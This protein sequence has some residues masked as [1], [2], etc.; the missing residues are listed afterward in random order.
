MTDSPG[1]LADR[2]TTSADLL[3]SPQEFADPPALE[4]AALGLGKRRDQRLLPKL[5]EMLDEPGFTIRVAEAASALMGLEEDPPGWGAE[6]YAPA[7]R[8]K[9]NVRD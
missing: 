6:D 4:E 1:Y 5:L 8:R 7:L 3:R 9:F 2:P